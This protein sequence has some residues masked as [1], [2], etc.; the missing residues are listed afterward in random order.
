MTSE[1]GFFL[2]HGNDLPLL[3]QVLGQRVADSNKLDWFQPD[4]ILIPQPSMQRWLQNSLADQFGIAANLSFRLPGQLIDEVMQPWLP[5][6]DPERHLSIERIHW[7][8]FTLFLDSALLANPAFSAIKYFLQVSDRQRR[9]WQLAG[10]VSQVFEKYQAWRREW[11]LDW[12]LKADQNDWQSILW[13]LVSQGRIF[14]AQAVEAYLNA[15]DKSDCPRPAGLPDRLFIFACQNLSP[16]V[17]R[18]L[19][20]F[21]R[22]IRVEFFL[23]NPCEAYWGDVGQ[24]L[25]ASEI[26]TMADDNPLLHQWGYAGRDFVASLLSDQQAEWRGEAEYYRSPDIGTHPSLLQALQRDVLNREAPGLDQ[27]E[28]P[29]LLAD[30]SIQIHCCAGALREV[31][32][33]RAQILALMRRDPRLQWR[34]IAIMAPDLDRYA[35]FFPPV[36]GQCDSDYPALPFALSETS[37]TDGSGLH[38]LF[39]GLLALPLSRFSV[40]E[41]LELLAHPLM[42]KA[43]GLSP[44]DLERLFVW[45][46]ESGV[47]WG[48][49]TLHRH[50]IDGVSQFTYTW[51]FALERLLY[52]YASSDDLIGETAP[53]SLPSGK[54][55]RLLNAL[56]TF[57]SRIESLQETLRQSRLAADWKHELQTIL[58]W[59]TETE[60]LADADRDVYEFL[61]QQLEQLPIMAARAGLNQPFNS[62]VIAAW[63]TE[64]LEPRLGQAWLSGRIT[65]CKMV[66]MRLIPFKIICLIG[67][68]ENAFPR[69][70]P[71]AAINRL[72]EKNRP[73]RL[74]D[75]NNRND[76]RFLMLQILSSCQS[77][78]LI[79]YSGLNPMDGSENPPAIVVQELLQ[80]IAAYGQ[81]ASVTGFDFTIRHP[82]HDF[83]TA[84]DSRIAVVQ[85]FPESISPNHAGL[86]LFTEIAGLDDDHACTAPTDIALPD[87]MAFWKN[88]MEATG[89]SLG[90]RFQLR[91]DVI[92]ETE[93]FGKASGLDRYHLA[94]AILQHALTNPGEN[95]EELLHR[96][97]AEGVLAPGRLGRF[98]FFSLFAEIN[99]ALKALCAE[100]QHPEFH[101]LEYRHDGLRLHGTIVQ[102]Y[103]SG[104]LIHAVHKKNLTPK[105]QVSAG[106][107]ALI[108]RAVGHHVSVGVQTAVKSHLSELPYSQ[109]QA[110]RYL[111]FLLERYLVGQNTI[112]CFDPDSSFSWYAF[113]KKRPDS[114]INDWLAQQM[115]K[116]EQ[117]MERYGPRLSD[118][119]TEGHGFL[120]AVA[121]RDPENFD[122]LSLSVCR[123]LSGEAE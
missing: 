12:H 123:I 104:V 53:V 28:P 21:G 2:H 86:P 39:L 120:K 62:E 115:A 83:E 56:A 117:T 40:N 41:G 70:D 84:A 59:L 119:L 61:N 17:L 105:L 111:D 54:D 10:E 19:Q 101:A 13:H 82:I 99:P 46:E 109:D 49:N 87:F 48:L 113:K 122:A 112:L 72:A 20:S 81:T 66:P 118:V 78:W 90:I 91:D 88:P 6:Q 121:M 45:L 95:P 60:I 32:M 89:R 7:R 44:E 65:I 8:I 97:Q 24:R 93:P 42:A 96:L 100:F 52:G 76:D 47:R 64:A 37:A 108:L 75:R 5:F 35:P 71:V 25:P 58:A 102:N 92:D 50:A 57:I 3:A 33:L 55:Q 103:R 14:R 94:E 16:D 9:A 36:F 34:D 27:F 114:H 29:A 98:R 22:W 30:N 38:D 68:D 77:N 1:P 107:Q 73:M 80:T 106:L 116:E 51:R 11:L 4:T 79:S 15:L 43:L 18:I 67:M 85:T 69:P 63:L 74:G 31:Q 23:H 26:L 110:C